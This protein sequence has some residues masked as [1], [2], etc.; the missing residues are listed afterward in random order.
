MAKMKFSEKTSRSHSALIQI[1]FFLSGLCG[2]IY[3]ILWTRMTEE[4]IGSAPFSISIILTVFM[5]G[6]GLGSYLAGRVIDRIESPLALV[7]V[8]GLLELVIG[9]Y[10][11][12]IP[13]LLEAVLPLQAFLYNG[14]YQHFIIYNLLTFITCAAVFCVPVVCMGATLPIL[15]RFYIGRL[16]HL[17][18]R[19][20][21]LYA[22]NT[23]GAAVGSIL[24][25]F[26]LI[27][28]LGM[29]ATLAAA[30]FIN[31]AIGLCCVLLGFKAKI[32]LADG[33]TGKSASK[34]KP[35]RPA[36]DDRPKAHPA[37]GQGRMADLRGL[38]LLQHGLRGHLD[39]ASGP[40]R[41]PHQLLLHHR[42][43]DFYHRPG[44]GK[45]GVRLLGRSD[46]K[47]LEIPALHPGR[48]R[49]AGIDRQPASRQQ[50]VFLRQADLHL[51]GTLR[52]P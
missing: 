30:V 11:L 31:A 34:E 17:G 9:A 25:G 29:P 44:V 46:Q 8:Y 6:L 22:L 36:G 16:A 19:A 27:Y 28:R 38:G 37:R 1:C 18:T 50:P 13:L 15:C 43:G 39:P 32:S 3:E 2:L 5:G 24:C 49:S 20:G 45:H 21:R 52:P 51:R 41:R 35:S 47:Q 42:V 33:R 4:I 12:L 10:A 26:F 7:K 23:I 48:R 40:H 14:W